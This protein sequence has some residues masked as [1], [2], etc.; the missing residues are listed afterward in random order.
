MGFGAVKVTTP[1]QPIEFGAMAATRLCEFIGFGAMDATKPPH[2]FTGFGALRSLQPHHR[3]CHSYFV[4][5]NERAVAGS[6]ALCQALI[7]EMVRR[8]LLAL[9]NPTQIPRI[10]KL[11]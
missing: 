2:E 4:Y 5:P 7:D 9:A 1:Y 10:P 3:I 11:T 8:K 6:A